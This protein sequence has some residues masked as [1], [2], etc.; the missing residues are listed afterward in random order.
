MVCTCYDWDPKIPGQVEDDFLG[1]FGNIV[2]DGFR[3]IN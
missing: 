2:F 1:R 3:V